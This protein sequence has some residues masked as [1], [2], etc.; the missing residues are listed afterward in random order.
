MLE[1]ISPDRPNLLATV[2]RVFIEHEINVYSAKIT[3]L[4]ERVEDV[5]LLG[6]NEAQ[7]IFDPA[8][9]KSLEQDIRQALDN[10]AQAENNY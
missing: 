1:V 9:L 4:G 3:T 8:A 2:A 6:S 7:K 5:F 10:Q